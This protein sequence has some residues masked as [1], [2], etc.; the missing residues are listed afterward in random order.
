V[1]LARGNCRAVGTASA[2]SQNKVPPTAITSSRTCLWRNFLIPLEFNTNETPKVKVSPP[3][4]GLRV[5]HFP[6]AMFANTFRRSARVLASRVR[7]P[8][9][10]AARGLATAARPAVAG[11][12][13][14]VLA[15]AAG[16]TGVAAAYIGQDQVAVSFVSNEIS[17]PTSAASL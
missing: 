1:L 7:A 6:T 8:V 9:A 16:L 14:A 12:S 4:V 15:G 2:N 13:F 5:F 17:T 10:S 3:P 11:S